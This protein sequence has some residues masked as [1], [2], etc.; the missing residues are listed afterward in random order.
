MLSP[1]VELR[2]ER[3]VLYAEFWDCL[4]LD[5]APVKDLLVRYKAEVDRAARPDLIVDFSGVTF[6]G[7]SSLGGLVNLQR[8]CRQHGGR[9]VLCNLESTVAEALR[10][11]RL[12]TLFKVADDPDAAFSA[13]DA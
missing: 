5:P 6:A 4:R 2:T 13:L 11:S 12:E 10:I 3:G 8:T 7:S 9:V 1:K